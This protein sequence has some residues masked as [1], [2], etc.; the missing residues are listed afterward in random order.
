[1]LILTAAFFWSL[2]TILVKRVVRRGSPLVAYTY[3]C[4]L[5]TLAFAVLSCA[6][7]TRRL[8]VPAG[9]MGA[10]VWTVAV[11]SGALCVGAAHVLYYHAIR[12]LGTMVCGMVNLA[13][14]F[15]P[16]L[17]SVFLFDERLSPWSLASGGLLVAGAAF[18]LRAEPVESEQ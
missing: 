10:W 17:L 4:T 16:P 7:G 13:N 11:A 2:Y 14:T 9:G 3:V 15:L 8:D 1:L 18:T 12:T 6:Q 5:M